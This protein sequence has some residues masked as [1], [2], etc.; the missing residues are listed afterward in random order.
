MS[1]SW[2]SAVTQWL[3]A[4]LTRCCDIPVERPYPYP[5]PLGCLELEGV[6]LY[7]AGRSQAFVGTWYLV[8]F[9]SVSSELTLNILCFKKL[10]SHSPVLADEDAALQGS[11]SVRNHLQSPSPETAG[12]GRL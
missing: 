6:T 3:M 5:S 11:P 2:T 8:V 4:L 12:G 9:V 7:P 1:S 10:P